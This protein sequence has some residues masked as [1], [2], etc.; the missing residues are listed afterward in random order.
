MNKQEFWT[1]LQAHKEI[2]YAL[3]KVYQSFPEGEEYPAV[4]PG[5]ILYCHNEDEFILARKAIGGTWTKDYS[6]LAMTLLQ[7]TG[8]KGCIWLRVDRG[9]VCE[10][11]EV[12]EKE[13]EVPD[14]KAY[15]PMVKIKEKVYEWKCKPILE[16][17]MKE[18][19]EI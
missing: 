8:H 17:S 7:K 9:E 3:E 11:V 15:I 13:V 6:D 18:G 4:Y 19:V 12:G 10:R 2:G 1:K 5:T 16:E 14:P